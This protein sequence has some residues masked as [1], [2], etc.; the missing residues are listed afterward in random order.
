MTRQEVYNNIAYNERIVENCNNA[1]RCLNAKIDKL[2]AL[3]KKYG[4]LQSDFEARQR[5]RAI[6]LNN[7]S[8]AKISLK[9]AKSYYESMKGM[10]NGASYVNTVNGLKSA[11]EQ[12]S[13]EIRVL[14]NEVNENNRTLQYRLQRIQYWK[15]QLKYVQE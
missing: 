3:L 13:K 4:K 12:I 9:F 1:I 8:N 10:I 15:E 11:Q 2:N 7:F 14:Q 5:K 6:G